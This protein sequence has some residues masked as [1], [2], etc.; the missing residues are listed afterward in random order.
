[1]S[2][3]KENIREGRAFKCGSYDVKG[4]EKPVYT[5]KLNLKNTRR[6]IVYV[7]KDLLFM[8]CNGAEKK[9]IQVHTCTTSKRIEL[10][11]RAWSG[12]VRF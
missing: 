8:S 10:E 1:M 12:F 2:K 6:L 11:S 5:E 3:Q 7:K 9:M 4:G